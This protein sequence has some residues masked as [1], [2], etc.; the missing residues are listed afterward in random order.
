MQGG[1]LDDHAADLHGFEHGIGCE[2]AG[3]PHVHTDF[4]QEGGDLASGEF[5]SQSAAGVFADKAQLICQAQV[6]KLDDHAIHF[7][8]QGI[9]AVSPTLAERNGSFNV[10]AVFS[11]ISH[12]EAVSAQQLQQV[13]LGGGSGA[14]D[15]NDGIGQQRQWALGRQ[16]RVE[17]A[18]R[19][20]S[21]IARV[22]VGA[23]SSFLEATV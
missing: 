13:P 22:E 14:I 9:T 12:G 4:T 2:H 16:G 10:G 8:G 21:S 18:K 7:E 19:T 6:V 5:E 11:N 15:G 23:L 1:L 3:A 17:L 20:S